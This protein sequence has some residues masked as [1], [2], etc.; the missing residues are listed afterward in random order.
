MIKRFLIKYPPLEKIL[1][2]FGSCFLIFVAVYCTFG[3]V[4]SA[5]SFTVNMS[6]LFFIWLPCAILI[7]AV[8]MFF[9]GKGIALMSAA[10]VFIFLAMRA[11][12]IEGAQ[13]VIHK[14]TEK[15]SRWLAVTVLFPEAGEMAGQPTIFI[16]AAGV[17]VA[18]LLAVAI[19]LRRN[20]FFTIL[21]TAPFIFLTFIITSYQADLIYLFGIIAVYLTL[22]ISSAYSPDDFIKRGL[23]VIPAF[24]IAVGIL[25][26]THLIAPHG[27]YVRREPVVILNN[28]VRSVAS[29]LNHWTFPWQRRTGSASNFNWLQL[30]NANFWQ[31]NTDYVN[32]ADAGGISFTDQ[33][34]LEITTTEPG[35]FYIRGYSMQS[36]D[37]R[38]WRVSDT[39]ESLNAA[40]ARGMPAQIAY[41]YNLIHSN[42]GAV[43]LV[44]ITINRTGDITNVEYEPYYTI[45]NVPGL[46]FFENDS[47]VLFPDRKF[48]YTRDSILTLFE[49]IRD[50]AVVDN[51]DIVHFRRQLS[52]YTEQVI[53]SGIYIEV[54]TYTAGGLRRLAI[55]AG[56]DPS[57][58]RFVVVDAV[59]R[60]I[61]SSASYTL[62]PEVTPDGEDFA[63]HFL[64]T[65]QEG[66]CIHFATAATLMLRSLDIPA[67]FVSGYVVTV[68]R[69]SVGRTVTLT[70]RN[71]HAW[72][73]V[74]YEDVGWL[75]LEVT[76]SSNISY[77]PEARPHTPVEESPIYESP[78]ELPQPNDD[79]QPPDIPEIN[80][81]GQPQLGTET[82]ENEVRHIP[83]WLRNI[84]ILTASVILC[85][86]ALLIHRNFK[87][88]LRAKQFSQANT[89][90]AVICMWKYI[91]RV[92]HC[93]NKGVPSADIEELALKARYSLHLM[94]EEERDKM[95]K[96]TARIAHETYSIKGHI[97]RLWFKY[98][99]ALY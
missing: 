74:F 77:V 63:L 94:T 76:P 95:S 72:V 15:Y 89:N 86:L 46:Q 27:D 84:I 30:Q 83:L 99:L 4:I 16:A 62:T 37:G 80:G 32:I 17:A 87:H 10:A 54:D 67:R 52:G 49:K 61:R 66:F 45:D 65:S 75:Y 14:I 20:A 85:I 90:A 69:G 47:D 78:P 24:A 48:F 5:F 21:F 93:N 40:A 96:Y 97:G 59:A 9:R 19:C 28:H 44:G 35:T 12:I 3:A 26:F 7:S 8:T 81:N 36:F 58:E 23:T 92:H 31:F 38:S 53:N 98:L 73:E 91:T 88:K 64:Q 13:F 39:D 70:D 6:T 2:L 22:F 57:A 25:F 71:A 60:L 33:S 51:M 55:E 79:M 82:N 11:D 50:T 41:L 1:T 29:Q 42:N 18:L 34:L 43:P 56:I 68:P